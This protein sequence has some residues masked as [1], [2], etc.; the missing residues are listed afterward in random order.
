MTANKP[1]GQMFDSSVKVK[2][3][4]NDSEPHKPKFQKNPIILNKTFKELPRQ[5]ESRKRWVN[6]VRS[7]GDAEEI[8]PFE[9]N[10]PDWKVTE[11][12]KSVCSC[13]GDRVLRVKSPMVSEIDPT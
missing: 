2:A 1:V 11:E 12:E 9:K 13:K 5:F 8:H 7:Q 6:V 4:K 3:L 10:L